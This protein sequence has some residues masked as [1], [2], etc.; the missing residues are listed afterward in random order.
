[1]ERFPDLS[2]RNILLR[3]LD[4]TNLSQLEAIHAE[5]LRP[6]EPFPGAH[7]VVRWG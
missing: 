5:H 6:Y 7:R 2:Q 1:V 4:N 3:R